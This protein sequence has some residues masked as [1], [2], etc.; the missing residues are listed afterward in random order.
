M[1]RGVARGVSILQ[2]NAKH[3]CKTIVLTPTCVAMNLWAWMLLGACTA[4]AVLQQIPNLIGCHYGCV[5]ATAACM[6][7][8]KSLLT[9]TCVAI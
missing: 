2:S 6:C 9:P 5:T 7:F 8:N 1:N 3:I 4:A